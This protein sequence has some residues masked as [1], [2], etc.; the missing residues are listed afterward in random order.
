MLPAA[1][2]GTTSRPATRPR[3]TDTDRTASEVP[4]VKAR[5][6][7]VALCGVVTASHHGL[8]V[9]STPPPGPHTRRSVYS[10]GDIVCRATASSR[11][12]PPATLMSSQDPTLDPTAGATPLAPLFSTTPRE[13]S[14]Q[15][16]TARPAHT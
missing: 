1:A 11:C 5:S 3:S 6:N 10:A 14:A 13:P 2:N 7:G 12:H 15:R 4:M 8:D 9:G 16:P